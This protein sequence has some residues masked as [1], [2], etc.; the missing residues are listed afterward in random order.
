MSTIEKSF[1]L[2]NPKEITK[3]G[4][5]GVEFASFG[6][7]EGMQYVKANNLLFSTS[8]LDVSKGTHYLVCCGDVMVLSKPHMWPQVERRII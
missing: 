4:D 7:Y 1:R 6:Y 8:F 3:D 5:T 2:A